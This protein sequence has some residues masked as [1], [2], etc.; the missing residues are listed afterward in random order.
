M[1]GNLAIQACGYFGNDQWQARSHVFDKGLI[2]PATL[3]LEDPNFNLDSS[4]AQKLSPPAGNQRIRISTSYNYSTN[5]IAQNS[6]RASWS[7]ALVIAWLKCHVQSCPLSFAA[8]GANGVD[9]GVRVSGFPVIS[10]AHHMAIPDQHGA[11][12]GIRRSLPHTASS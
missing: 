11:H 3:L 1:T 4:R 5:P 9:F 8:G 12:H 2:Q 6:F 7:A 10:L